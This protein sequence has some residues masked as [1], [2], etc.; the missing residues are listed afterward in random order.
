MVMERR[1]YPRIPVQVSAVVTTEDGVHITVVA[2]DVSI[3]G[4]G[5]ECNIKATEHNYAGREFCS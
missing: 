4:L 1:L 5:I 3:D 2:V